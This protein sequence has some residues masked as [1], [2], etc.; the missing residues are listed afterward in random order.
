[1]L[2]YHVVAPYPGWAVFQPE[3]EAALHEVIAKLKSPQF[4]RIG[5]RYIN[6]L[7]P[8]E[9][10][11]RGVQ[12]T[13]I[14]LT[15][16]DHIITESLGINYSRSFSPDHMV[17]VKVATPDLV[18]GNIQPGFSLLCDIDV[19]TQPGNLLTDYVDVAAWIEIAHTLEKAEFFDILP[20]AI[21]KKLIA[22][23]GGNSND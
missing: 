9:H 6:I 22:E 10:H 12:D 1:M 17:T 18:V 14:S 4:S 19:T 5:F 23:S 3:I 8:D 2:S 13:N 21:T 7:R 15:V 11:V 16:H 20:D